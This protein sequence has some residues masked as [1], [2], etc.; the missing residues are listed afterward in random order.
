MEDSTSSRDVL[1]RLEALEQ[2]VLQLERGEPAPV[3]SGSAVETPETRP[4]SAPATPGPRAPRMVLPSGSAWL[5]WIGR[6]LVVLGG[7]FLLRAITEAGVVTRSLGTALGFAY[8][9]VW[10]GFADRSARRDDRGSAVFHAL[11]AA[12]IAFP[13]VWEAVARFRILTPTASTAPL[14]VLGA[15]ASFVA[16]RQRL[17]AIAWIFGL[18]IALITWG[19]AFTTKAFVPMFTCLLVVATGVLWLAYLGPASGARA[20]WHPLSRTLS[21]FADAAVLLITLTL[22]LAD[23]EEQRVVEARSLLALQLALLLAYL[24]SFAARTLVKGRDVTLYEIAQTVAVL[25]I[26]LGG[27]LLNW[28][29]TGWAGA[30]LAS[31]WLTLAGISYAVVF[32]ILDRRVGSRANFI[33]YSSIALVLTVAGCSVVLSELARVLAFGVAALFASWLGATRQRAT[34]SMHGAIYAGTA[35]LVSGLLAAAVASFTGSSYDSLPTAAMLTVIALTAVSSTFPVA[36]HG[37][38]WGKWSHLP[39][40]THIALAVVGL[41]AVAVPLMLRALPASAASDAAVVGVVRTAVIAIA[42]V[43]LAW[44]GAARRVLEARALVAPILVL[45]AVKLIAEDLRTGRPAT[46]FLSMFLFGGALILAP[47]LVRRGA[48]ARAAVNPQTGLPH[49]RSNR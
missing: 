18:G 23:T 40:I 28:S 43:G 26:G 17:L 21:A 22:F 2:R 5:T 11:T 31:L 48:P 20:S 46:L 49:G 38:T 10:L 15:V 19:L 45:G 39:R 8:A 35:A 37:R 41:G 14:V 25:G 16:W 42:S 3:S 4:S 6:T 27:A 24:T 9:V 7:A 34:L 1:R 30:F 12:S 47:R 13:L 44:V 33:Y 32:L 36:L 29:H